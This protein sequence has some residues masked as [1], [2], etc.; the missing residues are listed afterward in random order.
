M[1]LLGTNISSPKGTF[2]SMIFLFRR[3]DMWSLPWRVINY[4]SGHKISYPNRGH[5]QPK[6]CTIARE[7]PQNYHTHL[8]H[9]WS[10]KE[11]GN[12]M[13]PAIVGPLFSAQIQVTEGFSVVVHFGLLGNTREVWYPF[14][15][16]VKSLF[17]VQGY[18][19][20]MW[21]KVGRWWK[22]MFF[23]FLGP[24]L[25]LEAM[26]VF[27]QGNWKSLPSS[28]FHMEKT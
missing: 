27:W 23:A 3:C 24:G 14:W 25:F 5:Y 2:E 9:V 22:M 21:K 28:A 20:R 16:V 18:K 26:S 11:I 1:T 10:P 13:T 7:I 15:V 4:N 6:Q 12:L 17:K 8:H 19:F